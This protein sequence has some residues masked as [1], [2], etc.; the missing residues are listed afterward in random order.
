MDRRLPK[1]A[2]PA[3]TGLPQAWSGLCPQSGQRRAG[4]RESSGVAAFVLGF[5]EPF[6]QRHAD[7][8]RNVDFDRSARWDCGR[9]KW[10]NRLEKCVQE[11]LHRVT[12][13][14][15]KDL[16]SRVSAESPDTAKAHFIKRNGG[17]ARDRCRVCVDLDRVESVL[18]I[19]FRLP[20]LQPH[21]PAR[22]PPDTAGLSRPRSRWPAASRR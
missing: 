13:V 1:R 22:E 10:P 11:R 12:G 20:P 15:D 4:R 3:P 19:Q 2:K 14:C 8:S 17:A 6:Q 21:C 5:A 7:Q 9:K 16:A 18:M